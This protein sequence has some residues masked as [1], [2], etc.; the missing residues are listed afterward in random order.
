MLNGRNTLLENDVLLLGQRK[1]YRPF[2]CHFLFKNATE[3]PKHMASSWDRN[4]SVR[5][6]EIP[7]ALNVLT[8]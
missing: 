5:I 3:E 4:F 6:W 8:G 2:G 7:L 1:V